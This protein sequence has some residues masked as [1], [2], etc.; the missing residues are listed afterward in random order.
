[1]TGP[2]GSN[3]DMIGEKL[4]AIYNILEYSEID[5]QFQCKEAKRMTAHCTQLESEEVRL[6]FAVL[7]RL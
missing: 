4:G 3:G 7:A 2:V 5:T 6:P 1:M